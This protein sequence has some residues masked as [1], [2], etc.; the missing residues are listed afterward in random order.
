MLALLEVIV[1]LEDDFVLN[2]FLWLLTV[3][4]V[5]SEWCFRGRFCFALNSKYFTFNQNAQS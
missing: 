1:L 3:M 5:G 4:L 2:T